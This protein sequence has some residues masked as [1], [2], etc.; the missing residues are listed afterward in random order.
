MK[1]MIL[2]LLALILTAC[3]A[4]TKSEY[5]TNLDKWQNANITHYR[6]SLFVGCFCP[7]TD[8]MPLNIE[9]QDG[10]VVSMTYVDGTPVSAEDIQLEFYSRYAT[11]ERLFSE[12]KADL[13]GEADEVTVTYNAAYGFPE[14]IGIDRIKEA[15][16]DELGLTV[17]DFE[18]M[19]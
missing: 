18:V 1:K 3:S 13:D 4:G 11:I 17:S 8:K 2:L 12:L 16:D 14:Q 6:F 10:K 15:I 5:D 9:V 19:K 7:G